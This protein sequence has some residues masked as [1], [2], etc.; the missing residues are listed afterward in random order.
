MNHGCTPSRHPRNE[1]TEA[2]QGLGRA[3]GR[4]RHGPLAATTDLS[5]CASP[6]SATTS[7]P[8]ERCLAFLA[9]MA[10]WEG[11]IVQQS[12][13]LT[14]QMKK[15]IGYLGVKGQLLN[16][17]NAKPDPQPLQATLWF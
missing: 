11:K 8:P 13:G 5:P 14:K 9:G 4:R 3:P 7:W 1:L 2:V 16:K 10:R 15:G 17:A 12:D 6:R